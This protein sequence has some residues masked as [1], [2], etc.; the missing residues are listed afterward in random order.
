MFHA[1]ANDT[2]VGSELRFSVSPHGV[3]TFRVAERIFSSGGGFVY[4]A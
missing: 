3:A 1:A 2:G 4:V